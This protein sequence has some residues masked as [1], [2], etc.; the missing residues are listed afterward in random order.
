MTMFWRVSCV[1]N[2]SA[3]RAGVKCADGGTR[4]LASS[5]IFAELVGGVCYVVG[6]RQ[7]EYCSMSFHHF[8]RN[9]PYTVK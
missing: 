4:D 1:V 2:A 5:K 9:V 6:R 3:T 8:V 7:N